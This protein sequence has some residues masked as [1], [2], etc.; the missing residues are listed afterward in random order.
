MAVPL[1][2]L[3]LGGCWA[4][5]GHHGHETTPHYSN[6]WL[7]RLEGGPDVAEL[8]A[9][10]LGYEF[11]GSVS[12][13]ALWRQ[14]FYIEHISYNLLPALIPIKKFCKIGN[15]VADLELYKLTFRH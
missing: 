2:V 4:L 15:Y 13:H 5:D 3:L 8:L 12:Q 10:E 11:L 9:L 14:L 7:V 6:E 1:V